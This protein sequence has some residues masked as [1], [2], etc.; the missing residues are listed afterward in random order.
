MYIKGNF[1]ASLS[2]YKSWLRHKL[3]CANQNEL[4]SLYQV[5]ANEARC[6]VWRKY[7]RCRLPEW[8]WENKLLLSFLHVFNT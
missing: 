3:I 7:L 5:I 1:K 4:S 8:L 2:L 6:G